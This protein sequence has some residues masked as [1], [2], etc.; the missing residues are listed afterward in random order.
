MGVVLDSFGNMRSGVAALTAH[1]DQ[2]RSALK[3]IRN[4]AVFEIPDILEEIFRIAELALPVRIHVDV[5]EHFR[6]AQGL[7]LS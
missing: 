4:R 6:P 7:H 2:Y 1:M 3:A 5:I